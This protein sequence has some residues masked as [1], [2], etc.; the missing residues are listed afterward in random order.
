MIMNPRSTLIRLSAIAALGLLLSA[1]A[2]YYERGDGV[3]YEPRVQRSHHVALVD[4]LVYPYWSLDHFYFSHYYHPFSVLVHRYDPWYYPYPGWYYAHRPGYHHPW[5]AYGP[6]YRHYRPWYVGGYFSFGD[7]RRSHAHRVRQL[8]ARLHELETRRSLAV[9]SQRPDRTVLIPNVSQRLPA[10]R[11]TPNGQRLEPARSPALQRPAT[12]RAALERRAE[13]LRRLDDRDRP[14][15]IDPVG[16]RHR[17]APRIPESLSSRPPTRAGDRTRPREASR[18]QAPVRQ[19]A[20]PP[21]RQQ[22]PRRPVSRSDDPPS[23][24]PARTRD[25]PPAR[26]NRRDRSGRERER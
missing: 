11:R 5:Y 19:R 23:R 20:T 10:N 14:R 24:S 9:R 18:S 22:Q 7:Y 13:L 4:P 17:G 25:R 21:A 16:S 15:T 1:C 3:Y 2:T 8:D 6:H 26:A 12:G